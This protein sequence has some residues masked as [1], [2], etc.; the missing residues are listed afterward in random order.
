MSD[1]IMKYGD[2]F[3]KMLI[4][5]AQ[6][7]AVEANLERASGY[8]T[9]LLADIQ[10]TKRIIERRTEYLALCERRLKAIKDN[11]FTVNTPDNSGFVDPQ[12]IGCKPI[13]FKD[14]TLN[15]ESK[16]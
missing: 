13:V 14:E 3:G 4:E 5:D 6:R 12:T 16:L 1:E 2:D 7:K 15:L 9:T 10:N 8:V 11:A